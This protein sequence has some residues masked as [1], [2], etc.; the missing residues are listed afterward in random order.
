MIFSEI[1]LE[2]DGCRCPNYKFKLKK[3]CRNNVF[4]SK[5]TANKE[6]RNIFRNFEVRKNIRLMY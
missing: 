2:Q 3:S 1:K 5:Q 4:R 6:W